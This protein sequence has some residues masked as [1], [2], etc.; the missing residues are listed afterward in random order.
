MEQKVLNIRASRI[1]IGTEPN[2]KNRP[3]G[4]GTCLCRL[5]RFNQDPSDSEVS[6]AGLACHVGKAGSTSYFE[7]TFY[8]FQK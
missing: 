2:N 4:R 6:G 7:F 5:G 1:A 3:K 8:A